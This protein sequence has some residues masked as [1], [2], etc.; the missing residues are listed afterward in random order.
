MQY[1]ITFA[2]DIDANDAFDALVSEQGFEHVT[3][4]GWFENDKGLGIKNVGGRLIIQ[5][6]DFEELKDMIQLIVVSYRDY[7]PSIREVKNESY[8][9]QKNFAQAFRAMTKGGLKKHQIS[10]A[11]K[12]LENVGAIIQNG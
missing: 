3:E 12:T 2:R 5:G 10:E 9:P 7:S 8:K 4:E 11:V 6:D 1:E